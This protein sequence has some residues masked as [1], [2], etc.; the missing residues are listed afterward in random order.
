MFA[1]LSGVVL[2]GA[3]WV[4]MRRQ[5]ANTINAYTEREP[6]LDARIRLLLLLANWKQS[7]GI[8]RRLLPFN[9]TRKRLEDVLVQAPRDMLS[10]DA[11]GLSKDGLHLSILRGATVLLAEVG[12]AHQ[13]VLVGTVGT[14][15]KP[16]KTELS[17]SWPSVGFVAGLDAPVAYKDGQF[18]VWS[19]GSKRVF[20]I[21]ELIKINDV[22]VTPFVEIA[23]GFI[24]I[25]TFDRGKMHF[26]DLRYEPSSDSLKPQPTIDLDNPGSIWP[27]YSDFSDLISVIR[28][29]TQPNQLDILVRSRVDNSKASRMQ[30]PSVPREKS[31]NGS[32]T[33][34][35]TQF[36]KSINFS[37]NDQSLIVRDTLSRLTIFPL[38]NGQLDRPT[39]LTIPDLA[40]TD[41]VRPSWFALRPVGAAVKLGDEW[42]V[43][44]LSVSQ[45][46]V[47]EF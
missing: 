34:E 42:R 14:P 4:Y 10:A 3:Q 22:Q 8:A 44:W 38:V 6:L 40:A 2:G 29:G 37:N 9:E 32:T 24:R 33:V 27:T 23:G 26:A 13:Q 18:T 31:T 19:S 7:D 17:N 11:F 45:A 35:D 39:S 28:G 12:E 16:P 43:S 25:T 20:N 1:L 36:L 41:L 15:E 30:L 46:S 21:D 47:M 5:A